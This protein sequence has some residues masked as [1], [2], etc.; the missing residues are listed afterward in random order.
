MIMK[1][2]LTIIICSIFL[3]SCEKENNIDMLL[4]IWNFGK[5]KK[6]DHPY[7]LKFNNKLYITVDGY[8][9][10]K[11][12]KEYK[13]VIFDTVDNVYIT[14]ITGIYPVLVL[15][16]QASYSDLIEGNRIKK[17]HTGSI[18]I[19][20]IDKNTIWFE[21]LLSAELTSLLKNRYFSIEFGPDKLFYRAEQSDKPLPVEDVVE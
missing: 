4:G 15:N 8:L 13:G 19:H 1:R 20:F 21:N 16:V 14:Q 7:T 10:F 3:L 9:V 6:T 11:K 5:I 12:D 17:W 2:I 18:K